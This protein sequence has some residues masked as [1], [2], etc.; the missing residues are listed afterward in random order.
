MGINML[1]ELN[2]SNKNIL[3]PMQYMTLLNKNVPDINKLISHV[4]TLQLNGEFEC[5]KECF[6]SVEK[7]I[8]IL[9]AYFSLNKI[10]IDENNITD[11]GVLPALL[12]WRYTKDYFTYSKDLFTALLES[13][14]I[15]KIPVH[16]LLKLKSWSIYIEF[17]AQDLIHGIFC[18]VTFK[19][20]INC[21]VLQVMLDTDKRLIPL[22]LVLKQDCTIESLIEHTL[23]YSSLNSDF[24]EKENLNVTLRT[25]IPLV[26][27][28]CSD[29]PDV[30]HSSKICSAQSIKYKKEWKLIPPSNPNIYSVGENISVQSQIHDY[31]KNSNTKCMHLRRGH[32][33]VYRVGEN[34]SKSILKWLWPTVVGG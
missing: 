25:I 29:K 1:W 7:W 24:T 16:M 12:T 23:N 6:L 10:K 4:K 32:W 33:H 3:R 34:R 22:S 14:S 27:Y 8:D 30:K 5:P 21:F 11:I 9:Q 13:D 26:L 17:P 19:E 15:N 31:H 18:S 28:I 20:D 2:N